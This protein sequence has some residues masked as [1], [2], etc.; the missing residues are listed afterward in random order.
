M[1]DPI[2]N[3]TRLQKQNVLSYCLMNRQADWITVICFRLPA[4]LRS[5]AIM[6]KQFWL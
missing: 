4:Y 1:R 6:E 3:V 5:Y 2:E